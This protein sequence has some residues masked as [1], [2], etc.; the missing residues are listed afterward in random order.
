MLKVHRL[1]VDRVPIRRDWS[2]VEV[3]GI[4]G[5]VVI[6]VDIGRNTQGEANGLGIG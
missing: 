3:R 4:A 1:T 5:V 2:H 6:C